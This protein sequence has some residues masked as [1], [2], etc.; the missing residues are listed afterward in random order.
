MIKGKSRPAL[1]DIDV[2]PFS[3]VSFLLIIFFILTTQIAAFKG[4]VVTIPSGSTPEKEEKKEE[5]QQLTIHL[6]GRFIKVGEDEKTPPTAY[7]MEGLKALLYSKR[8]DLKKKDDE[9]FVILQATN[10]VPYEIYFQV[11][12][13]IQQSNAILCILEDDE[14]GDSKSGGNAQNGGNQSAEKGK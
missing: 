8:Y 1:T 12:M 3:D 9:K 10:T 5:K 13:I 14:A 6:E 4:N 2:G 11:V 7:S